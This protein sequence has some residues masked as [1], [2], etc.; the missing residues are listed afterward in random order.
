MYCRSYAGTRWQLACG[1]RIAKKSKSEK[2]TKNK[3]QCLSPENM[4]CWLKIIHRPCSELFHVGAVYP[5][6]QHPSM[7]HADEAAVTFKLCY[8]MMALWH[9]LI[10]SSALKRKAQ[11]WLKSN[12][13]WDVHCLQ[14]LSTIQPDQLDHPSEEGRDPGRERC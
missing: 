7:A 12:R 8:I 10:H 4:A 14:R 6:F 3:Q 2:K 13:L 11:V 9:P 1:A 5:P